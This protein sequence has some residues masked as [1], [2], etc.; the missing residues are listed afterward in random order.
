LTGFQRQG[1]LSV[2]VEGVAVCGDCDV[3]RRIEVPTSGRD[4]RLS[5]LRF[6][7]VL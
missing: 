1:P 2:V 4:C 5:T 7:R 6:E 3:L